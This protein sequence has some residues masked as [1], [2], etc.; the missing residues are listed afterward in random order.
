MKALR[1]FFWLTD[2]G[3]LVYWSIVFLEWLP[4]EYLYPDYAN[5]LMVAW[6][7]SF[8]PLD[9]FISIT[10]LTS[11]YFYHANRN[12]RPMAQVSLVL[13]FCSGLQAIAFWG[14][15]GDFDPAWW[16][17]NLYLLLYPLFFY[18]LFAGKQLDSAA[19]Q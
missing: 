19:S 12:W 2:V 14:F 5:P 18:R 4:P 8:F 1:P 16:L 11:L 3:F 15:K 17:P 10:G 9:L 6:N 7:L 13:T